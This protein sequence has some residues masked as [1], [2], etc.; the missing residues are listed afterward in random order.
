MSSRGPRTRLLNIGTEET[1]GTED[2]QAA[3]EALR[4]ATWLA[5]EFEGYVDA[6]TRQLTLRDN[7]RL[8][9]CTDGLTNAIPETTITETIQ[10]AASAQEACER[11]VELALE[12]RAKDNVTAVICEYA[13]GGMT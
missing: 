4:A 9:L 7:D 5:T 11:L 3:A 10:A 8:L 2:I 12:R 6:E 1:K 13:F